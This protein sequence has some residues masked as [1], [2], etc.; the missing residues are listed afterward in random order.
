MCFQLH[1]SHNS[2][3]CTLERFDILHICCINETWKQACAATSRKGCTNSMIQDIQPYQVHRSMHN[4]LLLSSFLLCILGLMILNIP[5]KL[6]LQSS[7]IERKIPVLE[8]TSSMHLG[9]LEGTN[10]L[11]TNFMDMC[12]DLHISPSSR[13]KHQQAKSR[14]VSGPSGL[15]CCQPR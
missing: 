6:R 11:H 5:L 15:Q 2:K 7:R 9:N 10:I 3:I 12:R 8:R 1:S 4:L 14:R 13:R